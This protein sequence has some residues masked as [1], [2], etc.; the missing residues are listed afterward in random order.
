MK[1]LDVTIKYR[2]TGSWCN[3]NKNFYEISQTA[4]IHKS[5]ALDS[6]IC[7]DLTNHKD[8]SY[9]DFKNLPTETTLDFVKN[10][11][12]SRRDEYKYFKVTFANRTTIIVQNVE[13]L[14]TY[15]NSLQ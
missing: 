11:I 2:W 14:D 15:M 13:E 7:Y 10:T 5:G 8:E 1:T 9:V 6:A 12:K 4:L 3:L